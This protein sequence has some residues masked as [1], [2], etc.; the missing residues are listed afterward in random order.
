MNHFLDMRI[1]AAL[2]ALGLAQE[3]PDPN[4]QFKNV[5]ILNQK[6]E[7]CVKRTDKSV[8]I[9]SCLEGTRQALP[10]PVGRTRTQVRT[11]GSSYNAPPI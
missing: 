10:N 7:P 5:E 4:E 1:L 6:K 3:C 2:V 8:C 11:V 9:V